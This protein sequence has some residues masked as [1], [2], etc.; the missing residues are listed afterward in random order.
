MPLFEPFTRRCYSGE[1]RVSANI[2]ESHNSAGLNAVDA[3][4]VEKGSRNSTSIGAVNIVTVDRR[5]QN[6]KSI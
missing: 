2:G 6:S 3:V 4:P 5:N 1:F